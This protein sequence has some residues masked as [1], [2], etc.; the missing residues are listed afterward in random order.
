MTT[1]E[2][3]VQEGVMAGLEKFDLFP[4]SC[5]FTY[6]ISK[7]GLL[8]LSFFMKENLESFLKIINYDNL[9]DRSE[10]VIFEPEFTVILSGNALINLINK[11]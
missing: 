8:S 7:D 3:S 9:C 6:A 11:L 5:V 2:L 4:M 10:V 1:R